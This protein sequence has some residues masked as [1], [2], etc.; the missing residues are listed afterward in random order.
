MLCK[1]GKE[2]IFTDCCSFLHRDNIAVILMANILLKGR[3][4][5]KKSE[6]KG[7]EAQLD[8]VLDRRNHF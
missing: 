8:L 3:N 4:N 6:E 5:A 7:E 1:F 2:C